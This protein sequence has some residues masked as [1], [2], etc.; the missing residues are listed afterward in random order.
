MRSLWSLFYHMYGYSV[1]GHFSWSAISLWT[2][3]AKFHVCLGPQ[4]G[5]MKMYCAHSASYGIHCKLGNE[6]RLASGKPRVTTDM[7]CIG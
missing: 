6:T 2:F 5:K 7:H 4:D 3:N 1:C